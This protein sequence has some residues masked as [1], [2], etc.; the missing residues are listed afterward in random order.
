[1]KLTC[2]ATLL[3]FLSF[4][5]GATE[6]SVHYVDVPAEAMTAFE[7]A[8]N[9]WE[10]CL[11]TDNEI[12]IR[13]TGI[14]R[15]PTGF[16]LPRVVKNKDYL[17]EKD[18][19]YPSALAS[20]MAGQRDSDL[21][22]MNIFMSLRT[23]WHYQ[24]EHISADKTDYINVAM[25]E[26][27]HGLGISSASFV[28]WE[29]EK[30]AAIGYPNDFITFFEYSF[31]LPELDGTPIIYDK[32]I[33]TFEG[34]PITSLPN[35]SKVLTKGLTTTGIYFE[36]RTSNLLP[37]KVLVTPGNISHIP[38]Q[39]G[40]PTPIMLSDSG[41]GERVHLPDNILLGMLDEIGWKINQACING[42]Q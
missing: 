26:I 33:K 32:Y 29:G 2:Q 40:K 19:W 5:V 1:M 15:G 36:R 41:R 31:P 8:A 38:V 24:G 27:A 13:V 39:P 25:H 35:P 14:K 18:T 20:A 7:A 21:D 9:N 16:A 6:F 12:K 34:L 23:N 28:P 22:D 3:L 42:F 17:P 11:L 10:R 4:N 30:I 37:E